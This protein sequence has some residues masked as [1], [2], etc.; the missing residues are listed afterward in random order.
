M[1]Q[2][3]KEKYGDGR[4]YVLVIYDIV[5]DKR[6]LKL[7]KFLQGYGFRIQKSAFEAVIEKKKYRKLMA[8][9]PSY[10]RKEDS[11]RV[12][13]IV[14]KSQVTSFGKAVEPRDEDVIII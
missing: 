10:A 8:E 14:D 9:L 1:K 3:V 6:R 4:L 2:V 13:K 5:D 12:Y 7:S 11:I